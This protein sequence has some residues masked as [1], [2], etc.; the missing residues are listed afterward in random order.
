MSLMNISSNQTCVNMCCC[1]CLF[2]PMVYMFSTWLLGNEWL[3]PSHLQP[4]VWTMSEFAMF[5][6]ISEVLQTHRPCTIGAF[7]A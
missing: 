5:N 2:S 7:V 1:Q 4:T 3:P 6:V